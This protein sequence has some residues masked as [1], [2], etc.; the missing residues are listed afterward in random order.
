MT[1][2]EISFDDAKRLLA[3]PKKLEPEGTQDGVARVFAERH[4]NEL[5]FDHSIT[6]SA[7]GGVAIAMEGPNAKCAL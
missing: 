2:N 4:A 5:R 1:D 3:K 6:R 7:V